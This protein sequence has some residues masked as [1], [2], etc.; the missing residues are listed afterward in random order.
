MNVEPVKQQKIGKSYKI[1]KKMFMFGITWIIAQALILII[2]ILGLLF[3]VIKENFI[4]IPLI[5]YLCYITW[6]LI[7]TSLLFRNKILFTENINFKLYQK[8]IVISIY[9]I[10]ISCFGGVLLIKSVNN[11]LLEKIEDN[12]NKIT[13]L[14]K[15]DEKQ[16]NE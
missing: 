4:K 8:I 10:T 12:F 2:L 6:V 1:K 16:E 11:P 3:F 5:V 7:N 13:T 9:A 15:L 14:E